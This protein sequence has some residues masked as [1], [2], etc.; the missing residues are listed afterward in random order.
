MLLGISAVALGLGALLMTGPVFAGGAA[1]DPRAPFFGP[2]L[3]QCHWALAGADAV[4]LCRAVERPRAWT[5]VDRRPLL[6]A[7]RPVAH[8][9]RDDVLHVPGDVSYEDD[10]LSRRVIDQFLNGDPNGAGP[11]LDP[12]LGL[13]VTDRGRARIGVLFG[14][15]AI[16]GFD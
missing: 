10:V 5:I 2:R 4:R 16:V 9:P 14:D 8:V 13:I 1:A 15:R 3:I 7:R 12:S 6:T 11:V